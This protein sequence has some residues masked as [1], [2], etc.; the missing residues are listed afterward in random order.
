MKMIQL[1]RQINELNGHDS[2]V[3][4]SNNLMFKGMFQFRKNQKIPL[5]TDISDK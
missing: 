4:C 3:F 2:L 5:G 1:K